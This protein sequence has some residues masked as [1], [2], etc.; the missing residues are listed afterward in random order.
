MYGKFHLVHH[1]IIS[2]ETVINEWWTGKNLEGSGHAP[3]EAPSDHLLNW[4]EKGHDKLSV[5]RVIIEIRTGHLPRYIPGGN[6]TPYV[7]VCN[8][9]C[10]QQLPYR[11]K[12]LKMNAHLLNVTGTAWNPSEGVANAH[13]H[14]QCQLMPSLGNAVDSM[15]ELEVLYCDIGMS[16]WR[17][18]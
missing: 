16:F 5:V 14:I 1:L 8:S 7:G 2:I 12:T 17:K 9:R 18:D 4:T 10:Y 13:T 11:C 3:L 6:A 15:Q